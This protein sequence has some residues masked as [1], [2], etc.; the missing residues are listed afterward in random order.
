MNATVT[1][2]PGFAGCTLADIAASLPGATAVFRRNK[3]DFCCGGQV[4]LANATAAK[5]LSLPEL[6][7][8]LASLAALTQP[9]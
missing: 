9:A 4:S 5:G 7:A 2:E 3:L 6:D 1:T 8:E